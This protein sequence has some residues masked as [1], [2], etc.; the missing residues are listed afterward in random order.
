MRIENVLNS[1]AER[2]LAK[3]NLTL[4]DLNSIIR[5]FNNRKRKFVV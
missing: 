5:T 1:C 2:H 4:S 3:D